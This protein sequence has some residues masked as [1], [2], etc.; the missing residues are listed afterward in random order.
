MAL[1]ASNCQDTSVIGGA[2]TPQSW[3]MQADSNYD[4]HHCHSAVVLHSWQQTIC[5]NSPSAELTISKGCSIHLD[6]R[7][8]L[9]RTT[10]SA[11]V[12]QTTRA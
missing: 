12:E 8:A 1:K 2:V 5:G 6:S 7:L 10:A 9:R 4:G 3:F 11:G